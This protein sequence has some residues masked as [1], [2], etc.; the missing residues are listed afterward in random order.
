[1]RIWIAN[2]LGIVYEEVTAHVE[3]LSW[4][5][6]GI[7]HL[8]FTL[9]QR[10][11]KMT[12]DNLAFGNRIFVRFANGL[13]DWAGV[14]LPPRRWSASAGTVEVTAYT[15]EHLLQYRLTDRGRYFR[16]VS[17]GAIFAAIINEMQ[18]AEL[19]NI[20]V[21][22]VW[23]GGLTHSPAYHYKSAW[24]IISESLR[25]METCDVRFTPALEGGR[26]LWYAD[27]QER[28]GRNLS[29]AIAIVQG[30]NLVNDTIVEEQGNIVNEVS[31]I[32]VG[33]TWGP[34][35]AIVTARNEVSIAQY[36]LFQD[37]INPPG[38]VEP[39]TLERHARRRLQ[40]YSH[41]RLRFQIEV[42]DVEPGRFLDYDVGDTIMLEV[43]SAR[44][45]YR[46]KVRVLA[47]E[48]RPA[49]NT[50]GLVVEE[51][52]E[53]PFITIRQDVQEVA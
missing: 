38:V 24:W 7:G 32:G 52:P 36:G 37:A 27:L 10:D 47:R 12:P 14:I 11:T 39:I 31:A 5:L 1:M 44:W 8:R 3:S 26:I 41:P 45:G 13:P 35:R 49:N 28:I 53:V 42:A 51:E 29:S 43:P 34:D 21:N 50:C 19:L 30:R 2:K 33:T 22:R 20:I 23:Y 46:G 9:S 6:N 4:V 16:E 18:Y 17:A 48:Y 40:E 15:I 25:R